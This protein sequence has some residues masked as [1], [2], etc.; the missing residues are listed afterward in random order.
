V[1][2]VASVAL[3]GHTTR[4]LPFLYLSLALFVLVYLVAR[5]DRLAPSIASYVTSPAHAWRWAFLVWAIASLLWTARSGLSLSRAGTVLQIQVLGWVFFDAALSGRTR[6]V[7]VGV[8]VSAV[9]GAALVLPAGGILASAGRASGIF[10]NPNGLAA[11]S[12][13]GLCAFL[14]L[15]PS[16]RSRVWTTLAHVGALIIIAAIIASASRKGAMGVAVVWTCA[17]AFRETRKVALI[18][19]ALAVAAGL[20]LYASSPSFRSY[21]AT[22]VERSASVARLWTSMSVG[23][24]SVAERARYVREGFRLMW[25]SPLLGYGLDSFAWISNEGRCSHS[26]FVELGVSLGIPGLLLYYGVHAAILTRAFAARAWRTIEGRFAVI[27]VVAALSL[28]VGM[29]SYSEKLPSLLLIL[30]AG[31]VSASARASAPRR[32]GAAAGAPGPRGPRPAR[33]RT[34]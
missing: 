19:V 10:G 3:L 8:F 9:V 17:L 31:W 25:G 24:L 27:V 22:A 21:W 28:D 29:I 30:L 20:L 7:A 34:T 1:G 26:N 18:H 32:A 11:V 23:S 33:R 2:T 12:L 5:R 14:S 16:L 15:G 13:L 6:W 4:T